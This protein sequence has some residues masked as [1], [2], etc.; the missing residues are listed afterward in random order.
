MPLWD[1]V[2]ISIMIEN[3]YYFYIYIY[4]YIKCKERR[5]PLS[6]KAKVK[7]GGF[8]Q[9]C[10][11]GFMTVMLLSQECTC[12]VLEKDQAHGDWCDTCHVTCIRSD[13]L[14]GRAPLCDKVWDFE[15][16][17]RTG[18]KTVMWRRWRRSLTHCSVAGSPCFSN[19]SNGKAW[20]NHGHFELCL[21]NLDLVYLRGNQNSKV[22][23]IIL[24]HSGDNKG[25]LPSL[26]SWP[27]WTS[28]ESCSA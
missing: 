22:F 15:D 19:V 26:N 8:L 28:K 16:G 3:K 25:P 27:S 14:R 7:A 24:A 6:H 10:I 20:Y 13:R 5:I 1:M 21:G 17:G 9:C 4:T 18:W 11:A 23:E 12:C 2:S